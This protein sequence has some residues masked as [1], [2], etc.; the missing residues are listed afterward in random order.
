MECIID[1]LKILI[2]EYIGIKCKDIVTHFFGKQHYKY[3]YLYTQCKY[4][5]IHKDSKKIRYLNIQKKIKLDKLEISQFTNL[6]RLKCFTNRPIEKKCLPD[7][8]TCLELDYISRKETSSYKFTSKHHVPNSI[9]TLILGDN[10]IQPLENII[11]PNGL[12]SL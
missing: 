8:I 2:C 4:N 10:F 12:K 9:I 1:D 3:E 11:M 5:I 6:I 7:N